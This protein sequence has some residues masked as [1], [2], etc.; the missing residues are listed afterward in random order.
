MTF[1]PIRA[2]RGRLAWLAR[3]EWLKGRF[4]PCLHCGLGLLQFE[5]A[6]GKWR[7]WEHPY[8]AAH[9]AAHTERSKAA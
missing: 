4:V 1:H 7:P 9:P 6:P 5:V 2:L 3:L 8:C